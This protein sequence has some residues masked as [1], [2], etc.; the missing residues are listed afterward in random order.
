MVAFAML[1]YLV[2]IHVFQGKF[3]LEYEYLH[4]PNLMVLYV[5][6][7]ALQI[8]AD[9]MGLG[10]TVMTI[11]LILSNP[12]GEL[13][14]DKRGTRD[15]DTKAQT[16][17]SSVRGGTLIIC[18]MALLGQWKVRN[19]IYAYHYIV[20][21]RFYSCILFC[22]LSTWE[23]LK[24][25]PFRFVF[26]LSSFFPALHFQAACLILFLVSARNF[27][28]AR[29]VMWSLPFAGWIGG[30]FNTRSSFCVCLLWWRQNHWP[31]IHGSA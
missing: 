15:R 26:L 1:S 23:Q 6:S 22:L 18:P 14:Q 16:S 21:F 24:G 29:L 27:W 19:Y 25:E 8:L 12:R 30:T 11:A 2:Y 17:R 3:L 31:E 9:A 5:P 4:L 7:F 13:E 10:K 20:L 28:F